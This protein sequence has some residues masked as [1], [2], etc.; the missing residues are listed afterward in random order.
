[1]LFLHGCD[2]VWLSCKELRGIEKTSTIEILGEGY[3]INVLTL[4]L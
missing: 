1:M 2:T 4:S 3:F